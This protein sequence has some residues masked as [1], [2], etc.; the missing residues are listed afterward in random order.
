[1]VCLGVHDL[2]KLVVDLQSGC[3]T[4]HS[5]T[6]DLRAVEGIAVQR[7]LHVEPV[8]NVADDGQEAV[9]SGTR[10]HFSNGASQTPEQILQADHVVK[11]NSPEPP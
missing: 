10:T 1:M 7:A 9:E 11:D 5:S 6:N 3:V 8:A 4:R 2:E